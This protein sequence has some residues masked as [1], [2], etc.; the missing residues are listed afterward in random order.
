MNEMEKMVW[1]AAFSAAYVE[2]HAR[3]RL[4]THAEFVRV[5]DD[6][7]AVFQTSRN[8]S[9]HATIRGDDVAVLR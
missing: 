5:A 8:A 4:V 1:A 9:R 2:A 7:V 3:A 6:A